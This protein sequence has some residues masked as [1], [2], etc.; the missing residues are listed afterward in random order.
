MQLKERVKDAMGVT[1]LLSQH[2]SAASSVL[3]L[4]EEAADARTWKD[5]DSMAEALAELQHVDQALQ[6]CTPEVL[7]KPFVIYEGE[8]L[9]AS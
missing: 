2:L 1:T 6:L 5:S 7:G 8:A 3:G 9:A 4:G